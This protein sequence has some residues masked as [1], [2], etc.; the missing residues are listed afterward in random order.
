MK[1]LGETAKGRNVPI[2]A[3]DVAIV[4]FF[5]AR[6]SFNLKFDIF[7]LYK[8]PIQKGKRITKMAKGFCKKDKKRAAKK[9]AITA[10]II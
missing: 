5:A 7:R 2:T 6:M 3:Q 8:N 9:E 4:M 10:K 1:A